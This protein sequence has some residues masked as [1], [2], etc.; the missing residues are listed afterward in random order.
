[1]QPDSG[2]QWNGFWSLSSVAFVLAWLYTT[3]Y[4]VGL[5]ISALQP[6]AGT[7]DVASCLF[8]GMFFVP[9]LLIPIF[10]IRAFRKKC[11]LLLGKILPWVFRVMY[12]S[13][14][15]ALC[16]CWWATTYRGTMFSRAQWKM[17]DGGTTGYMGFG[18]DLTYFRRIGG[19]HYGPQVWFWFTPFIIDLGHKHAQI[20]WIWKG[21]EDD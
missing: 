4:A 8:L 16:D 12:I 13:V 3:V 19:S 10:L 6:D 9:V 14:I 17:K 2:K 15:F 11:H 18:Y 21:A 1:M 5:L 7:W 20:C